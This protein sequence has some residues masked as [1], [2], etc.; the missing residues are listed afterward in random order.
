M[1]DETLRGRIPAIGGWSP[2]QRARCLDGSPG[3]RPAMDVGHGTMKGPE[4]RAAARQ[5]A[6]QGVDLAVADRLTAQDVPF[7]YVARPVAP[8][9]IGTVTICALPPSGLDWDRFS[10][11]V[12]DRLALVPRFR[13]RVLGVPGHLANPVWVD[14]SHFDLAYHLRRSALPRPG[15]REQLM[16]LV[17]RVQSRPLDRSRPLWE[18]YVVEGLAPRQREGESLPEAGPA[19]RE[20]ALITKTHQ[21]LVDGVSAVDLAQ[22]ILDRS[23]APAEAN[24]AP[25]WRPIPEPTWAELVAGA[26]A[27][28]VRSPRRLVTTGVADLKNMLRRLGDAASGAA[29]V[30]RTAARFAAQPAPASP[31]N[32]P[33]GAQRRFAT[34]RADLQDYRR[35]RARQAPPV[36]RQ[37]S[38]AGQ[39]TSTVNDVVLT[40]LAGGL[41]AWLLSRGE[42]VGRGSFLRALVPVSVRSGAENALG[43]LTPVLTAASYF[44][45]LPI[46]EPDPLVR[47]YQVGFRM[48]AHNVSGQRVGADALTGLSGFAPPTLHALGARAAG[49]LSR[50]AYNLVVTNV[51]GPQEPRY[52]AGAQLLESYP[53]VPLIPGQAL[54]IGVTSYLGNV[55]IGLN[56]DRDALPDLDVVAQCM[57]DALDELIVAVRR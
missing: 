28:S 17:A 6:E 4:S 16:E 47:L 36:A 10:A 41:R 55:C 40:V 20:M 39:W 44:V 31:L 37:A 21:A 38:A 26:V 54:S 56:A 1:T 27:D 29:A 43:G 7:L 2:W 22:V 49:G 18:M 32:T 9:H 46:G 50:R 52:V 24:G 15:T 12:A 14:D 33:I 8:M 42:S 35:I 11:L 3:V 53:V 57:T 5:S 23:P 48:R 34:A 30:A 45:D 13:Q 25:A 51:P 19:R